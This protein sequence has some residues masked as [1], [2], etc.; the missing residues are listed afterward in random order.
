VLNL[1]SR[2][3]ASPAPT[4]RRLHGSC[5]RLDPPPEAVA[6]VRAIFSMFVTWSLSSRFQVPSQQITSR[7]PA[8]AG[9]QADADLPGMSQRPLV[10]R[11]SDRPMISF[12]ISVV[13]P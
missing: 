4:G 1:V 6:T 10:Y 9:C 3:R 7:L 8:G 2:T 13:P 11:P 12:W 5:R